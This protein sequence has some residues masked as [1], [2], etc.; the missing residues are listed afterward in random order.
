[1]ENKRDQNR[2]K[3]KHSRGNKIFLKIKNERAYIDFI[4]FMQDKIL[5]LFSCWKVGTFDHSELCRFEWSILALLV[6]EMEK[7]NIV[8]KDLVRKRETPKR[9]RK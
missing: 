6:D 1:M 5:K 4:N 8:H 2:R 9:V 3:E 7:L